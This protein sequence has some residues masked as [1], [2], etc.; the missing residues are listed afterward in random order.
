MNT[1]R[2]SLLVL[3]ILIL[4]VTSCRQEEPEIPPPHP[5]ETFVG[6][7]EVLNAHRSYHATYDSLGGATWRQETI[8][9]ADSLVSIE[10]GEQDSLIIKGLINNRQPANFRQE[11]RAIVREDTLR[12]IYDYDTQIANNRIWG[13]IWLQADSIFFDYRWSKQDTYNNN[14]EP[15]SGSVKGRGAKI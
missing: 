2:L 8:D 9:I 13:N 7:Y 5:G 10:L 6:E 4:Q 1:P 12:I 14:P 3:S 11:V 15:N